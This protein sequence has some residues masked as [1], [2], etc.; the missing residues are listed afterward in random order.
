MGANG[1]RH[2]MEIVWNV[3]QVLGI[4][5]MCAAQAID[6]RENGVA[7]MGEGT[8]IA[9]RKVRER[10]AFFDRDKEMT[11]AFEA[12]ADLVVS[13]EILEAVGKQITIS[14]NQMKKCK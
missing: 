7:G 5:L 13:E 11:P 10:V 6:L 2:L 9:Y 12:M 14:K 4:E 8:R 3:T 1:A